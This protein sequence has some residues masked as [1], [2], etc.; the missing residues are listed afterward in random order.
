MKL[1]ATT[2]V[3]EKAKRIEDLV[4][5]TAEWDKIDALIEELEAAT[6]L[7]AYTAG[8]VTSRLGPL[9]KLRDRKEGHVDSLLESLI[10]KQD[11]K[12]IGEFLA[13]LADSK[14]QLKRQKFQKHGKQIQSCLQEHIDYI[15]RMLNSQ[16]V[17]LNH[18][19]V[20]TIAKRLGIIEDA[21]AQIGPH[22][23]IMAIDLVSE[24]KN[25]K[26]LIDKKL[27][28]YV[29]NFQGACKEQNFTRMSVSKWRTNLF[30]K[31]LGEKAPRGATEKV[32]QVEDQY[33]K[34]LESIEVQVK[35]FIQSRFENAPDVVRTLTSLKESTENSSKA[36]FELRR[37]YSSSTKRLQDEL[38]MAL[39]EVD[40]L[41]EQ[42]ACFD[43]GIM[44]LTR[45]VVALDSG[46][47]KHID[48]AS[49]PFNC[50]DKL[51]DFRKRAEGTQSEF[52]FEGPD[53]EIK[54]KKLSDRL[55][56]L[57]SPSILQFVKQLVLP[58]LTY[59]K[60]SDSIGQKVRQLSF[61]AFTQLKNGDVEGAQRNIEQLNLMAVHLAYHLP[62]VKTA[63]IDV[64]KQA[65]KQFNDLLAS[66]V[67][68]LQHADLVAFESLFGEIRR[69]ALHVPFVFDDQEATTK[70]NLMNRLVFSIF[71]GQV[72]L[73]EKSLE[74]K[75]N[76]VDFAAVRNSIEDAR[77]FGGFVADYFTLFQEEGKLIRSFPKD[78]DESLSKIVRL[79]HKY[80]GDGR[81]FA[82]I[83]FY[84]TLGV[85]PSASYNEITLAYKR[86]NQN[87]STDSGPILAAY[88]GLIKEDVSTVPLHTGSEGNDD[89]KPR[90]FDQLIFQLKDQIRTKVN[91]CLL[92]QRYEVVDDLLF[93]LPGLHALKDLVQPELD[94]PTILTGV[95]E[96]VNNHCWNDYRERTDA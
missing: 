57:R 84:A 39:Q 47:D 51:L 68:V 76:S 85:V 67:R 56:Q 11:F 73:V 79:C 34:S 28:N 77:K 42:Q 32:K 63:S 82:K 33:K 69:F 3:S 44:F 91:S 45:V 53:I 93:C 15:H 6:I 38:S 20:P 16:G 21:A 88:M 35:A 86:M 49:L 89:I 80:F 10:A 31:Y 59:N 52:N 64:A 30:V 90:P 22:L 95:E 66:A 24:I 25:I 14:D 87:H 81:D 43:E 12:G 83:C 92:E 71:S 13:P 40:S 17:D 54:L 26:G 74:F 58:T 19:N 70:F 48:V 96:L 75:A 37:L 72:D 55:E 18:D 1:K 7:D 41:V 78:E 5:Q 60:L 29:S 23:K 94:V 62:M 4:E 2:F 61:H 46:I 36:T 65:F 50:R 9:R 27:Q 8:Q